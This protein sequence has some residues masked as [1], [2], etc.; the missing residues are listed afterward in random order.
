MGKPYEDLTSLKF[1]SNTQG[2]V[3]PDYN[4]KFEH[5]YRVFHPSHMEVAQQDVD[6]DSGRATNGIMIRNYKD[7]KVSIK[8]TFPP[9]TTAQMAAVLRAV[10]TFGRITTSGF[11]GFQAFFRVTYTDPLNGTLDNDY[12]ITKWF[13]AGDRT[14]P[15]YN[16]EMG[17]WEEMTVDLVER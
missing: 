13:Y 1:S 11:E 2:L 15:C 5:P 12:R 4:A 9:M 6:L 16:E 7:T 17:L 10:S 3:F 8:L 14:S